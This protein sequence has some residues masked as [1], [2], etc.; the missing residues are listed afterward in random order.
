MGFS[1]HDA[2]LL[3]T[4]LL[5]GAGL[6]VLAPLIRI[7]YPILL[8]LGGLAIGFIP[9]APHIELRPDIVLVAILPLLARLGERLQA[10]L[11]TAQVIVLLIAASGALA[12]GG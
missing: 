2:L 4:L 10:V 8:V 7:P 12:V 5:A 11:A 6:L 3:L 9:G 1:A